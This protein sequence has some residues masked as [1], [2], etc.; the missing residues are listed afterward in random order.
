MRSVLIGLGVI[1]LVA[2]VAGMLLGKPNADRSKRLARWAKLIM[3][4]V[5]LIVGGMWW[6]GYARA[7]PAAP[8][9][10]LVFLGLAACA[11]GDV[12]LAGLIPVRRAEI[13]SLVGFG[14]GHLFFIAG[15]L[16]LRQ[17]LGAAGAGPVVLAAGTGAA[18]TA[19]AWYFLIQNPGGSRVLNIA[20]LLYG[21]LLGSSVAV[22]VGLTLE[23]GTLIVMAVGLVL[24]MVSDFLVAQHLIRKRSLFP[25][26][27][28][29][30]WL[31]Y[32]AAQV[33]I[34]IAIGAAALLPY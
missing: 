27:R 15:V 3:I 23:T 22:A 12:L 13:L 24:F 10:L 29:A 33:L 31:V 28:D 16:R 18:I 32:S 21:M 34:A 4:A 1:W 8:F 6:I 9:A 20:S 14:I 2:F 30:M 17:V 5:T 25:Y 19:A 11:V 26:M 7:T